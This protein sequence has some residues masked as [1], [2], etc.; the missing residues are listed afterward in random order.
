MIDGDVCKRPYRL[1]VDRLGLAIA[2]GGLSCGMLAALL[3]ALGGQDGVRA[4]IGALLIGTVF[5]ALAIAAVG[6]PIWL[7]MHAVGWR[8]PGHAAAA[9]A[10]IGFVLFLFGQSDVLV[11]ALDARLTGWLRSLGSSLVLAAIAAAVALAMWRVAYRR[12][13]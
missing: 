13:S 3:V 7:A 6:G 8:G 4:L 11:R 1:S 2:L 9:G 5:S 10:V 12:E